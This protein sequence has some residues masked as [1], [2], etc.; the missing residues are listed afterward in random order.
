MKKTKNKKFFR[1]PEK[2]C[3]GELHRLRPEVWICEECQQAFRLSAKGK[4]E[5]IERLLEY[6]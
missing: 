6:I 2:G 5:K 3:R 4:L 1:C